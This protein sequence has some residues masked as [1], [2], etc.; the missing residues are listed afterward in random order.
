MMGVVLF[1]CP[2]EVLSYLL[3][4]VRVLNIYL[5]VP[6]V[7]LPISVAFTSPPPPPHGNGGYPRTDR[8]EGETFEKYICILP[9]KGVIHPLSCFG[10]IRSEKK[11]GRWVSTCLSRGL[12]T[13]S[14]PC[15]ASNC[16]SPL[17]KNHKGNAI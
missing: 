2:R 7:S 9:L 15:P 16:I 1:F 3:F 10:K 6:C 11:E 4:S 17:C 14:R 13:R 5:P 8:M 12:K